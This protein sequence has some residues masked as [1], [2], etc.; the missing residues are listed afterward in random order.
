MK[1]EERRRQWLANINRA[2]LDD[3]K[4][5]RSRVCSNHLISRNTIVNVMN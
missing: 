5:D 2:D 3:T 4:A 1:S